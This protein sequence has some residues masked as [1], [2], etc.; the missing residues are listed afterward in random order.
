MISFWTDDEIQ[1]FHSMVNSN[2]GCYCSR[3][4]LLILRGQQI[5]EHEFV[6]IIT[7]L[8]SSL[9][10]FPLTSRI[11]ACINTIL[12]SHS[13]NCTESHFVA[14]IVSLYITQKSVASQ[15]LSDIKSV[16]K[17]LLQMR[18]K[19]LSDIYFV[20]LRRAMRYDVNMVLTMV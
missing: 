10:I 19:A 16:L 1:F 15:L 8:S 2:F 5:H 4:A 7:T 18:T 20:T 14:N 9:S 3:S 6:K 17:Y 11:L 12:C 13:K